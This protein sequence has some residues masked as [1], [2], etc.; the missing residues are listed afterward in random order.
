MKKRTLTFIVIIVAIITSMLYIM[1]RRNVII[2]QNER[3]L[4]DIGI[5]TQ[6]ANEILSTMSPKEAKVEIEQIDELV[7][8]ISHELGLKTRGAQNWIKDAT[9]IEEVYDILKERYEKIDAEL[10]ERIEKTEAALAD[11]ELEYEKADNETLLETYLQEQYLLISNGV[12][13]TCYND[14]YNGI[15][16]ANKSNCLTPDFV[17]E[18]QAEMRE[19]LDNLIAGAAEDGIELRIISEHRTYQ[20]QEEVFNRYIDSM[21]LEG[22]AT[23]SAWPGASEHQTGLAVDLG[24]SDG[25]C[26]LDTCFES[27][28][29]GKWL[30]ENA[31]DYGFILR[32]PQGKRSITGYNYEPWHFRYIGVEPA[33]E[34]YNEDITL[35]EY[36]GIDYEIY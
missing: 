36:L 22:A 11:N 29:E 9:S 7:V 26:D 6:K 3:S 20:Y 19:A 15:L 12:R 5:S 4:A 30:K 13:D 32:Y 34:I 10:N 18:D 16:I 35:E 28:E 14:K 24:A 21:G 1:Q 33:V 27:T 31:H 2:S 23:I 8:K 25:L 17:S